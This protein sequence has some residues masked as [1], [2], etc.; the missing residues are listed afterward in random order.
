[1]QGERLFVNQ[2]SSCMLIVCAL[3]LTLHVI[4]ISPDYKRINVV[5]LDSV[6]WNYDR[7]ENAEGSKLSVFLYRVFTRLFD[8]PWN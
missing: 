2:E 5:H 1:M 4:G 7:R 6:K 8:F 3:A